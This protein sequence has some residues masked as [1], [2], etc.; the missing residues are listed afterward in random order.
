MPLI[1]PRI[2]IVVPTRNRAPRLKRMLDSL[3]QDE[4]PNKEVIVCDGLST[5]DTVDLLKSYG[6]Q[7]QWISE[8][9]LGEFDARNKGLRLAT[10]EIIRYMSDDDVPVPGCFAY[11]ARYLVENP[12]VDILFGQAVIF[13]ERADGSVIPVDTR[14][15]T[16]E[17]VRLR[18]FIRSTMPYP[19]SETAFFRRNVIDKI[20]FFDMVLGAD[21][22]YWARAANAGL[23]LEVC[24]QV[25]LHYYRSSV[26]E[27]Q[28]GHVYTALIFCR[29]MLARRYGTWGDKLYVAFF[30]I[31]R[32]LLLDRLRRLLPQWVT[33]PLRKVR[34]QWMNR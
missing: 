27:I 9:D 34:W 17:S 25:F 33:F 7:V 5:D 30:W 14:L 12:K 18:N 4:Y 31:P 3:M 1:E 13:Y 10:G 26:N 2:S 29:W 20:G 19:P 8:S 22:E 11:A 24:N 21:H 23:K 16:T 15:R 32:M 6:S 28:F